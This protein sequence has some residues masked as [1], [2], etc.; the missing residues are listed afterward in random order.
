[1][2]AITGI[3]DKIQPGTSGSILYQFFIFVILFTLLKHLFFNKLL[4]V[5]QTRESKTTKLDE[6][7]GA[8]FKEAENLSKKFDDEIQKTNEEIHLKTSEKK[9]SALKTILASQKEKEQEVLTQY[10][11]RKKEVLAEVEAKKSEVLGQAGQLSEN[12][13]NKLVN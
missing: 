6:E 8:K 5:I 2:E 10:E 3:L 4:F 11:G 1:M 9:N 12:L 7:A 13:I